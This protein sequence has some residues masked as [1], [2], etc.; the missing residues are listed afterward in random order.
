MA[1]E[2]RVELS[3][4]EFNALCDLANK[5]GITPEEQ[6]ALLIEAY[7]DTSRRDQKMEVSVEFLRQ[8]PEFEVRKQK[9]SEASV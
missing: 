2:L 7:F 8:N 9:S 5:N 6:A 4:V 3:D 1:E